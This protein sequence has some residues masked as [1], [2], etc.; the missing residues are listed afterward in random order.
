MKRYLMKIDT[1]TTGN[2]N[3]VTP[4][5]ADREAFAQLVA[6][7]AMPFRDGTIDVVVAIDALGFILGTAVAESL[8]VG[9]VPVR[10]GGKLPVATERVEFV[11]YS[12]RR[13]ALEMRHD[14]LLPGMNVLI[15]DEWIE[16]GAQVQAAITL[17][18]RLAGTVGGIATICMDRNGHTQTLRE[19]YRIHSVWEDQAL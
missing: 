1:H 19:T 13:K 6:D 14:A 17:V 7:L 16:T 8:G 15:V 2:R 10:K 12:G 4:L 18:T 5:F 11:D 3:D 9:L